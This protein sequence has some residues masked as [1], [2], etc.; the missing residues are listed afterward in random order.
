M[1]NLIGVHIF[2]NYDPLF[3]FSHP[4]APTEDFATY[5]SA[6]IAKH[7]SIKGYHRSTQIYEPNCPIFDRYLST[8]E[9]WE[10]G[11]SILVTSD[12][13]ERQLAEVEKRDLIRLEEELT[14]EAL[15][16]YPCLLDVSYGTNYALLDFIRKQV[17]ENWNPE[18]SREARSITHTNT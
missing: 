2:A 15:L 11:W 13:D 3:V 10:S 1:Y 12:G 5:L 16:K 4:A 8:Y 6:A 9:K 18:A 17:A 7:F 14:A